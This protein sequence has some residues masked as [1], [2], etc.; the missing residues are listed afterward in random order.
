MVYI[1]MSRSSTTS[2]CIQAKNTGITM[3]GQIRLIWKLR[4]RRRLHKI[5]FNPPFTSPSTYTHMPHINP[6]RRG[7]T[8]LQ[9][10][11]AHHIIQPCITSVPPRLKLPS[12][13]RPSIR[14]RK[15][16]CNNNYARP[17]VRA[18][19]VSR[20]WP[21]NALCIG[22]APVGAKIEDGSYAKVV[23]KFGELGSEGCD[24]IPEKVGVNAANAPFILG[25]LKVPPT[26]G[27]TMR[28]SPVGMGPREKR[29]PRRA[30]ML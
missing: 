16:L 9:H 13:H 24:V 26:I 11:H 2:W 14:Q 6:H 4:P 20:V 3:Q 25:P 1:Y 15:P 12:Q 10:P 22:E 21:N 28:S 29:S 23:S 27:M 5:S 18:N 30:S 8:P 17:V 19:R 7:P